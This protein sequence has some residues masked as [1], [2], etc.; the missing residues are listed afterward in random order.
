LFFLE[1]LSTIIHKNVYNIQIYVNNRV[2]SSNLWVYSTWLCKSIIPAKT[3][4]TIKLLCIS[5]YSPWKR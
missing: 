2:L 3:I 1:C 5:L 4:F